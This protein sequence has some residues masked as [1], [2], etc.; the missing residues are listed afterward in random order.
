[1]PKSKSS[2]LEEQFDF[3]IRAMLPAFEYET[4]YK[5]VPDRRFRWDFAFTA[6]SVLVEVQGG[7]WMKKGGHNTA[8]GIMRDIEKHNLATVHGYRVI[9]ITQKNI[10]DL[11][12]ITYLRTILEGKTPQKTR[13]KNT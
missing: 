4:E 8:C 11:S 2:T 3:Q 7:L 12:G 13:R 6:Q 10:D 5:A 1:M 9:Y